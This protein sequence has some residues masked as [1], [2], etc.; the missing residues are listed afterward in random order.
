M[1]HYGTLKTYI[2][3]ARVM[4]DYRYTDWLKIRFV[5]CEGRKIYVSPR[6]E[7]YLRDEAERHYERE[8]AD[9]REVAGEDRW[10]AER[11]IFRQES[12]ALAA[13]KL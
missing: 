1:T 2:G 9:L 5:T 11:E 4:V 8:M 13:A 3:S 12:R 6:W 10:E 7:E